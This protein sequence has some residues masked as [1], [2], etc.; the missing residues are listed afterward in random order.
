MKD[1]K[2]LI[3][4]A[5]AKHINDP[6]QI[7]SWIYNTQGYKKIGSKQVKQLVEAAL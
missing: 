5:K 3:S 2:T 7:A 6:R 1:I 4:E